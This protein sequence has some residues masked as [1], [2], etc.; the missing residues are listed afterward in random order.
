MNEPFGILSYSKH[1]EKCHFREI[2]P[3]SSPRPWA[4]RRGIFNHATGPRFVKRPSS[5][6]RSKPCGP[7]RT[8]MWVWWRRLS[9][10][11][12]VK[13]SQSFQGQNWPWWIYKGD[14][15]LLMTLR[16]TWQRISISGKVDVNPSDKINHMTCHQERNCSKFKKKNNLKLA[17]KWPAYKTNWGSLVQNWPFIGH[18]IRQNDHWAK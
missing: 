7:P 2:S 8:D 16:N 3:I 11:H 1:L 10:G 12:S 13:I 6:S 9:D 4:P 18:V 15:N 14:L 5:T 17:S